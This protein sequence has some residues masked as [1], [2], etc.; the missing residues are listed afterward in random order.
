LVGLSLGI[1]S[2]FTLEM[3]AA[4]K[5]CEKFTKTPSFEASVLSMLINL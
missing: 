5:N 1:F 4:A 2:Q 3:C